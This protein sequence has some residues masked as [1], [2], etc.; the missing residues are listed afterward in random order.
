[1]FRHTQTVFLKF[2]R[3]QELIW[4][5]GFVWGQD[6]GI[7]DRL[8]CVLCPTCE[9]FLQE[10]C[11]LQ[12]VS[13]RKQWCFLIQ[14]TSPDLSRPIKVYILCSQFTR[15]IFS[16]LKSLK[17]YICL[18]PF[19]INSLLNFIPVVFH[20][21]LSLVCWIVLLPISCKLMKDSAWFKLSSY[22]KIQRNRNDLDVLLFAWNEDNLKHTQIHWSSNSVG[23]S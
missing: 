3:Y 1:M 6:K 4:L 16:A 23:A 8:R 18:P 22:A 7:V 5:F 20:V 15:S 14:I 13:A 21:I 19:V 12:A 11:M 9:S 10:F 17:L 2:V